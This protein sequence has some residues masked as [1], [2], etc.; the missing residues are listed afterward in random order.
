SVS[1]RT[2]ARRR[3]SCRR[4]PCAAAQSQYRRR[5]LSSDG[6][7]DDDAPALEG[8]LFE[9]IEDVVDLVELA[10]LRN[11][12]NLPLASQLHQLPELV[13]LAHEA[14]QDGEFGED[15]IARLPAAGP[16]IAEAE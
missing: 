15:H 16:A 8:P 13:P 11:H 4:S 2:R 6:S 9:L 1:G 14:T 3:C 5:R 7:G 12:S 10:L